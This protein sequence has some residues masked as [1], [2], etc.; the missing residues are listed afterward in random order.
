M[1]V[2]IGVV[3]VR[4]G[5]ATIAVPIA[6]G[7]LAGRCCKA[8][9]QA[10]HQNDHQE[11]THTFDELQAGHRIPFT[12]WAWRE[13]GSVAFEWLAVDILPAREEWFPESAHRTELFSVVPAPRREA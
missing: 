4:P 3:A 1:N 13:R 5:R 11:P 2:G 6:I 8:W 10:K 12:L 9:G 7:V